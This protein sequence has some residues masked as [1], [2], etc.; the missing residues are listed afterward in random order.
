MTSSQGRVWIAGATGLVGS[1]ALQALIEDESITDILSFGRR[2]SGLV[3][4]KLTEK[5]VDFSSFSADGALLTDGIALCFLGT[6]IA[7]AG[8]KEAFRAVDLDAVVAFSKSAKSA[9][10]HTLAVVTAL[11]ADEKS[12]VFY[13]KVKGEAESALRAMGFDRLV[14]VQP[15]LL[16][17]DRAESRPGERAAIVLSRLVRPLLTPFRSRPIEANVVARATIA[18]AKERAKGVFVVHSGDLHAY[19]R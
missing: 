3:S 1:S 19:G 13:N 12:S 8:S 15:S 16:L 18:L 6:T 14:L 17:G 7:R 10:A 2:A 5:S 4:P 11:G 9:G